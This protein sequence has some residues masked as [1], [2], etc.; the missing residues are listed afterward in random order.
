MEPFG[1]GRQSLCA[2]RGEVF[3]KAEAAFRFTHGGGRAR[4]RES[5]QT[6][7]NRG[8]KPRRCSMVGEKIFRAPLLEE[9]FITVAQRSR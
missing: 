1:V 7:K 9:Y 2:E 3:A 5:A 6:T 8:E 4:S